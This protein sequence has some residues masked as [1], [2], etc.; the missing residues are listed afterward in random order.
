MSKES[1]QFAEIARQVKQPKPISFKRTF[2]LHCERC[3]C[4]RPHQ[5]RANGEWERYTCCTCGCT[6]EFKVG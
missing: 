4:I 1:V 6:Q 5:L 2:D 3:D